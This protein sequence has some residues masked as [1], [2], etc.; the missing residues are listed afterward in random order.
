MAA[1]NA[2]TDSLPTANT[3]AESK[4]EKSD[5][6]CEP[7]NNDETTNGGGA[8]PVDQ[9]VP[10]SDAKTSQH[11]KRNAYCTGTRV[12]IAIMFLALVMFAAI[13]AGLGVYVSQLHL[14]L[15]H[16]SERM[17]RLEIQCNSGCTTLSVN[18]T[19]PNLEVGDRDFIDLSVKISNLSMEIE[20]VK[21]SLEDMIQ[22]VQ[23]MHENDINQIQM[24]VSAINTSLSS[25]ILLLT[26]ETSSNIS[27]L[28][29]DAQREI[30]DV[31]DYSL[32]LAQN[33]SVLT[34][35]TSLLIERRSH[36]LEMKVTELKRSINE[37][38]SELIVNVS[39]NEEHLRDISLTQMEL[40]ITVQ[41]IERNVSSLEDRFAQRLTNVREDFTG[42]LSNFNSSL[43]EIDKNYRAHFRNL[44]SDLSIL[45]SNLA[46]TKEVF[47]ANTSALGETLAELDKDLAYTNEHLRNL[48]AIQDDLLLELSDVK[49]TH[50]GNIS[51][52]RQSLKHLNEELAEAN[53]NI[54]NLS[55]IQGDL[56]HHL[57][58]TNETFQSNISAL[59]QRFIEA[60]NLTEIELHNLSLQHTELQLNLATTKERVEANMSALQQSLGLVRADLNLTKA[61]LQNLSSL[62]V[63][64]QSDYSTTKQEFYT[65][66]AAA[67]QNST[68]LYT[69]IRN[70]SSVLGEHSRRFGDAV[71]SRS[72]LS[73]R[74]DETSNTVRSQ[75]ILIS[76]IRS[77]V[78]IVE[79]SVTGLRGTLTTNVNHL[80]T[81]IDGH[82]DWIQRS[83]DD[84]SQRFTDLNSRLIQVEIKLSSDAIHVVPLGF[85]LL[86]AIALFVCYFIL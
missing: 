52:I 80:N 38:L 31:R 1:S 35:Q 18:K 69:L 77:N 10:A 28:T 48:S 36:E 33:V 7:Q 58:V 64:L 74:I 26:N 55:S 44:S 60:L 85:L 37:Q 53:E 46:A 70:H 32:V 19:Q 29:K 43:S 3:D 73:H 40:T 81:L 65:T 71:Q 57:H 23:T 22:T 27:E 39:S 42:T 6:S 12:L 67:E 21:D 49:A 86:S 34:N 72:M 63:N 4:M 83:L 84:Q 78:T 17:D 66:R 61:D 56:Q 14:E 62:Q 45:S 47:F 68:Q 41:Q 59:G 50:S 75:G 30:S 51:S 2:N 8:E 20:K 79:N 16:V 15:S 13:I 11:T 54:Q 5:L 76:G 9:S 24:N 82:V 25:S